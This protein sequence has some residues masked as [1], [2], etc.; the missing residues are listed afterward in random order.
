MRPRFSQK[1]RCLDAL[2]TDQT[3][4]KK[5]FEDLADTKYKVFYQELIIFLCDYPT[6]T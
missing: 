1:R 3:F 6:N 4:V 5:W 2:P